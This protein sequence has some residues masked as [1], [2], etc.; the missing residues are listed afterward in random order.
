[1]KHGIRYMISIGF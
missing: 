1:M